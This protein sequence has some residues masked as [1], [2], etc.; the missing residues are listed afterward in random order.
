ME[1]AFRRGRAVVQ[2]HAIAMRCVAA[3]LVA[4]VWLAVGCTTP[5][6]S[7]VADVDAGNWC[8]PAELILP[9]V[10]TLDCYDWQLFVR[11]D[12]RIAADTFTV[13]IAVVT[14]DSLRFEEPFFVRLPAQ[15]V[16]AAVLRETLIDYRRK[17]RL[18]RSGDYRLTV[19]PVRPLRG[20]EAVG[21]QTVKS[22]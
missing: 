2:S 8:E 15:S 10:D 4:I 7:V 21:I 11:N 22:N 6:R 18:F 12:E 14:P 20:I 17:V 19:E 9:N 5:Y 3:G 1:R 13:R 16:P